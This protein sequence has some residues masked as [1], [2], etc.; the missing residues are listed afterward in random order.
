MCTR[1]DTCNAWS[2]QSAHRL[3]DISTEIDAHIIGLT[4]TRL[5][6]Y[7]TW[8]GSAHKFRVAEH[9]RHFEVRWGYEQTRFSNMKTAHLFARTFFS[10][11]SCLARARLS[12]FNHACT[13]GSSLHKSL[14]TCD[15]LEWFAPLRIKNTSSSLMSH[16]NLLGLHPESFTSF[17]S[18]SQPPQTTCSTKL[19]RA[20]LIQ[21]RCHFSAPWP[22]RQ[23]GYLAD[24]IPLTGFEAKACTDVSSEHTAISYPYRKNS[25]NIEDNVTATVAASET[26][27]G[28]QKQAAASGGPQIVPTSEVKCL[29]SR[30]TVVC[31][32][33]ETFAE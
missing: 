4:G 12:T 3:R 14:C 1:V 23:S 13:R 24:S 33:Q 31:S 29:A 19:E 7:C 16:P 32:Q 20:S 8:D 10:V 2:A 11:L 25:F 28:F 9:G 5:P 30:R 18:T 17:S 6:F 26:S 21:I 27:D 15:V 22:G